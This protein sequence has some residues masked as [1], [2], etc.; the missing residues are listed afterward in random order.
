MPLVLGQGVSHRG[1]MVKIKALTELANLSF[2]QI[3]TVGELGLGIGRC[4]DEPAHTVCG[5]R[6]P[7]FLKFTESPPHG[8]LSDLVFV[9][10]CPCGCELIPRIELPSVDVLADGGEYPPPGLLLSTHEARVLT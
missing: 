2:Q 1:V 7:E 10:E 4:G 5:L 9:G 3:D 6:E 8:H